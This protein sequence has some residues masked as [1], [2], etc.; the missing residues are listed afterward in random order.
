MSDNELFMITGIFVLICALFVVFLDRWSKR[1]ASKKSSGYPILFR[2]ICLIF[3]LLVGSF[4]VYLAL[5][6][7]KLSI[8]MTLLTL[9]LLGC[10]FFA[11]HNSTELETSHSKGDDTLSYPNNVSMTPLPVIQE[12]STYTSLRDRIRYL[13]SITAF[14]ITFMLAAVGMFLYG[15]FWLAIH[16]A[17]MDKY[18]WIII[19]LVVLLYGGLRITSFVRL[20]NRNK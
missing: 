10:S 4:T 18:G 7:G 16:P 2:S 6:E 14:R 9:L 11:R 20:I 13:F 3:G 5:S 15:A 12:E 8:E 19:L 1:R 17:F